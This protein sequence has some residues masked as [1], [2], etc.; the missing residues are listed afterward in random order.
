[1]DWLVEISVLHAAHAAWSMISNLSK[2]INCFFSL[3]KSIPSHTNQILFYYFY[4]L[5]SIQS[6]ISFNKSHVISWR[7]EQP[8]SPVSWQALERGL[9]WKSLHIPQPWHFPTSIPTE[10]EIREACTHTAVS[11]HRR[12]QMWTVSK[13]TVIFL[14]Y[15]NYCSILQGSIN[16]VGQG[17]VWHCDS[18][19]L[20]YSK[21]RFG[22]LLG[23]FPLKKAILS[24]C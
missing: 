2:T 12:Y 3:F 14:G 19:H 20:P 21:D 4:F 16:K 18:Q 5:K 15:C 9:P 22:S 10:A 17:R 7:E 13:K 1:M 24:W 23:Y 8:R 11:H 6:H